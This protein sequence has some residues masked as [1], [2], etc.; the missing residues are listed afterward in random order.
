MFLDAWL[1][2][3]KNSGNDCNR[4]D[5]WALRECGWWTANRSDW[6]SGGVED[7]GT[8]GG[9]QD[10]GFGGEAASTMK[11]APQLSTGTTR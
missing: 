9:L 7:S 4:E 3:K 1:L 6:G 11:E 8:Q 2:V 10:S 5:S